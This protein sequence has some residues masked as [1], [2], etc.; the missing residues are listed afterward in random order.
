MTELAG[1]TARPDLGLMFGFRNPAE[2]RR[3]FA[4]V[5]AD[6]LR[7]IQEA[8][9]MGYDTIWLTEHHF[10]DDGYS[11]SVVTIAAA[12]AAATSRIR[13]GFNLLLLP[14]HNAIRVAEDVATLDVISN[15]RID[16]GVGQ[17][18]A[19]HEFRGYGIDRSER[20]ARFVE[21]LDVLQGLW[22]GERF[23]YQGAH[24]QIDDARLVPK[25]VQDPMAIWI[26]AN[27]E[28]G[29][30]RAGR[31][32]ANLLGLA[33]T[34]LQRAYEDA[35]S[36]AGFE[37]EAAKVLQLRWAHVAETADQAWAEAAPHFHHLL[38]VYA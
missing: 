15:G 11:P 38:T 12:I 9:A 2:W 19:A 30:R 25:L 17:G 32:G 29:V 28:T 13:I 23:S 33:S 35:W 36:A 18:Y 37:P 16:F 24:Y 1:R 8:E 22:S 26:G 6:D 20:L 10:A 14:L 3:P 27:T 34:N 7:L 21:G 5:Y 4:D 31:R